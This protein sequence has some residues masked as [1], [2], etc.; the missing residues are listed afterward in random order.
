MTKRRTPEPVL[1][2][3]IFADYPVIEL[4]GPS[5]LILGLGD[6]RMFGVDLPADAGEPTERAELKIPSLSESGIPQNAI[7]TRFL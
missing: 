1:D 2:Q 6:G 7:F 5:R 3:T 4:A